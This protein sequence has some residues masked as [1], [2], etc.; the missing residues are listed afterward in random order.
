MFLNSWRGS[1]HILTWVFTIS[2]TLYFD[3]FFLLRIYGEVSSSVWQIFTIFQPWVFCLNS[4][5]LSYTGSINH[6]TSVTS[7]YNLD[8]SLWTSLPSTTINGEESLLFCWT[9]W[10]L[11]WCR[12]IWTPFSRDGFAALNSV[13]LAAACEPL[14]L[15]LR[16]LRV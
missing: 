12:C 5:L 16:S 13:V 11:L 7:G 15:P 4:W 9:L 1:I 2:K 6:H 8:V 3:W 14:L 10:W